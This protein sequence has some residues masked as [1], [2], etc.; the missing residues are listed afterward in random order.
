MLPFFVGVVAYNR[1]TNLA[2]KEHVDSMAV[3]YYA[4]ILY[5]VENEKCTI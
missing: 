1:I 4:V 2:L 5:I 3:L